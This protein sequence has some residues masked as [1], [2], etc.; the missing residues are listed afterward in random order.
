MIWASLVAQ[1]WRN[2]L[3][4]RRPEFNPRV[5]KI[6]WRRAWEPTPVSCLEKPMDRGAW[7]ATCSPWG[8]T[9]LEMTERLSIAPVHDLFPFYSWRTLFS[10]YR[11]WG[12]TALFFQNSKNMPLLPDPHEKSAF[13]W[14]AV[15]CSVA[16]S[17][18]TL[19]DLLDYSP[20]DSSVHGILQVRYW[21]VLPCPPPG[22]LP[23]PGIAASSPALQANLPLRQQ[24][25]PVWIE[26]PLNIVC[27]CTLV[28]GRQWHPT[29]VLLPG[30]SHG[31]RSLVGC[32]PWGLEEPDMIERLHVHFHFHALEKEMATHST[33]LA[34]RIPGMGE[35]GGLPSMGSHKVGHDWRNLAAAAAA[36]WLV[37][38]ILSS[39]FKSFIMMFLGMASL[40]SFY[41]GFTQLLES[42]GWH[43]LPN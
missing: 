14:I 43:L 30:K 23:N 21:N 27:H 34:W 26:V 13:V 3:Q 28:Q 19:C 5:G 25:S 35:P 38:A 1:W 16:Q 42:I 6:P 22:D 20:P 2:C 12:L 8:H 7:W 18:L 39:V 40:G 32:G 24:G 33:V 29:P 36:L 4:C 9:E 37:S 15:L 41:L 17:C 11:I 31:R 10:W